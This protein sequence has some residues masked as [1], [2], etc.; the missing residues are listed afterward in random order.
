M[1]RDSLATWNIWIA[2]SIYDSGLNLVEVN[3]NRGGWSGIGLE[4]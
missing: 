1:C 4:G 3:H 2:K